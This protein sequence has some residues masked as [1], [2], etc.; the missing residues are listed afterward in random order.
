MLGRLNRARRWRRP[1][2]PGRH[3][4][5]SSRHAGISS[6]RAKPLGVTVCL[7]RA[8]R[9]RRVDEARRAVGIAEARLQAAGPPGSTRRNA[10]VR[11]GRILRQR[12]QRCAPSRPHRGGDGHAGASTTKAPLFRIV[13]YRPRRTPRADPGGR[14]CLRL[15]VT[16]LAFEVAGREEPILLHPR[17]ARCRHRRS[18]DARPAGVVRCGESRRSAARRADGHGAALSA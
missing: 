13:R 2:H 3:G 14:C 18:D 7:Q 8:P 6:G 5:G 10:P 1:R 15:N 17:D 11:R 9:A 12:V 16:E 4:V